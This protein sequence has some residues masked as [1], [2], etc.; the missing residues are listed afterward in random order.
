MTPERYKQVGD[1]FRAAQEMPPEQRTRFLADACGNDQALQ[2]EVESLLAYAARSDDV[3]DRSAMEVSAEA[4]ASEQHRSLERQQIDHYEI[5]SL[6]GRGG[7]GEVYRGRD[8]RLDR[9]VA[10]KVLPAAYSTD[11]DRLRRFEQEA[12]AAG[13]LNH[14]NVVT[15]YDVGVHGGAPYIVTELLEGEELRAE[16]QQGAI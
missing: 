1:L 12:R 15:V 4:L 2:K 9:A 10:V 11:A 14:P 13:K 6:V 8:T 3:I 16:L 7:M 5:V